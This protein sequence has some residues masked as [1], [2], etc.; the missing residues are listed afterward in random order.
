MNFRIKQMLFRD[1]IK[2][3]KLLIKM[4]SL[5]KERRRLNYKLKVK[6][7]AEDIKRLSLIMTIRFLQNMIRN[8]MIS[9]SK[10]LKILKNC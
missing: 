2:L 1:I 8:I 3:M 10:K 7:K 9:F 6:T 4:T 5:R